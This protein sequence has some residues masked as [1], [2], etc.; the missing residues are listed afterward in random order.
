[1]TDSCMAR[2]QA[3]L[4]GTPND[5]VPIIPMIG[6]WPAANFSDVP[7]SKLA[8]DPKRIA[9]AQVRAMETVGHDAFFAYADPLYIPEAFG[10][11]VRFTETGLLVDALPHTITSSVWIFLNQGIW[12]PRLCWE[13]PWILSIHCSWA[14]ENRWWKTPCIVFAPAA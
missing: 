10:C 3:A 12:C 11:T 6:G 2:F 7:L 8:H 14:R 9:N 5:R 13:G 1:M 4:R